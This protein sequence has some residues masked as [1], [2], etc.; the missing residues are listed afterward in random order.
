MYV[1]TVPPGIREKPE[2]KCL[3]AKKGKKKK[4]TSRSDHLD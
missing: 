2:K 1:R 4:Y 3:T